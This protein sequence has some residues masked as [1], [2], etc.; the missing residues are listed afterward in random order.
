MVSGVL[1]AEGITFMG[2]PTGHDRSTL[3]LKN[4]VMK[5]GIKISSG[6]NVY[7]DITMDNYWGEGSMSGSTFE[8]TMREGIIKIESG[9]LW[10]TGNPS[11]IVELQGD[12]S[13]IGV[14][15]YSLASD[16]N[17]KIRVPQRVLD[18][19]V[20][21]KSVN[22]L[23]MIRGDVSYHMEEID[24][25]SAVNTD[26]SLNDIGKNAFCV[27]SF[28]FVDSAEEFAKIPAGEEAPIVVNVKLEGENARFYSFSESEDPT[29]AQSVLNATVQKLPLNATS[30]AFEAVYNGNDAFDNVRITRMQMASRNLIDQNSPYL[31]D[32][33]G[34]GITA[35]V[36]LIPQSEEK[37][38]VT[39]G[40]DGKPA[41]VR[42]TWP[43]SAYTSC[44][45]ARARR[46]TRSP[47]APTQSSTIHSAKEVTVSGEIRFTT[48]SRPNA[49]NALGQSGVKFSGEIVEQSSMIFSWLLFPL[50]LFFGL[51]L[52]GRL[53]D[54]QNRRRRRLGGIGNIPGA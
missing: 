27:E 13:N 20:S 9:Y 24:L 28:G 48:N 12:A 30:F 31:L 43:A 54:V 41:S 40:E 50:L 52:L 1:H 22:I 10:L 36:N 37:I 34:M 46:I 19:V 6:C 25:S 18:G 29:R 15:L 33:V 4:A 21:G 32:P 45:R 39:W 44:P 49:W 11:C 16:A 51:S 42:N 53:R 26:F 17:V 35:N 3:Y 2:V 7:G 23:N 5:S 8:G 38:G 14:N 47:R